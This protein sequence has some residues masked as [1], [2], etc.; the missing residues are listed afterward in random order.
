MNLSTTL[1][2]DFS[3]PVRRKGQLYYWQ[4]RVRIESGS[5]SHV[6]ARVQGSQTYDVRL[7]LD[8]GVLFASCTCSYFDSNGPCKHLWATIL[9]AE[10][11]GDLSTA[12]TIPNL[13]LD[14]DAVLVDPDGPH[15]SPQL[16]PRIHE[17]T[18]KQP[19][20]LKQIEDI[21][22][23]GL[24]STPEP[25][26][27]KREIVY[28]VDVPS[29]VTAGCLVLSL[30]TRD[31]KMDGGWTRQ[32]ALS[33]KRTQIPQLP[34]AEDREILSTLAGGRVYLTYSY[35][36]Y[37]TIPPACRVM[38]PL[39]GMLM[40]KVVATGRCYLR[41][42]SRPDDL[43]QLA[44]D[45]SGAWEFGLEMSR[46]NKNNWCVAGVLRRGGER[47]DLN[48]AVLVTKGGLVFTREKVAPLVED[49]AFD[50]MV[51][52]RRVGTIQAPAEEGD[53]LLAS[54]LC[55]PA[56][57]ALAV[58]EELRYQELTIEPQPRLRILANRAADTPG[59][60]LRAELEFDYE[61]RVVAA[62]DPAKGFVKTENRQFLRRDF[63]AEQDSAA[64]LRDL[65]LKLQPRGYGREATWQIEQ[66][67]LPRVARALVE[68]SWHIEADGRMFRRS[69]EFRMEVS[70]GIDWFELHGEVEY[71]E[72]K[73]SLPALLEALRRG[74][75]MVRLDDGTYGLLPEEWMRRV[76]MLVGLGTPDTNHIRFRRSQAGLLD[77]LLAAQPNT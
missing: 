7:N 36:D 56:A 44:W 6:E 70:S 54:L 63:K 22:G 29:S 8:E 75:Q 55:A 53:E 14:C 41:M 26:P 1:A 30:V 60:R 23:A 5:H 33:L 76:G 50:W 66:T 64:L 48:A 77:A 2:G 17:Y 19:V 28:I 3:P 57:P 31:R 4:R 35:G 68:K 46:G 74:E 37:D 73:A 51:N 61:G 52:L 38:H 16:L 49:A 20:W 59:G 39:A 15:L 11:R 45:D 69:G 12:A 32:S 71:G 24:S 10:A 27:P 72:T 62:T 43:M 21:T 58:P 25:F 18:P 47:I 67:R 65:G 9:A 34:V 40:P 42:S 13:I